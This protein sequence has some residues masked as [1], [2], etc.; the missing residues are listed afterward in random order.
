MWH[1]IMRWIGKITVTLLLLTGL[2][3]L[4]PRLVTAIHAGPRL[5][6][7]QEAPARTVAIVF[8]AGLQ[9]DGTPTAVLRDRVATAA[10]LY[11]SGKVKKIL[12]SGDNRFVEY[13]EPGAMA[14][15][16]I[17]LGVPEADIVLDYA[18]RR[19]YDTCYRAR[20]IFGIQEA[21][22]VTQRFHLPRALYLCSQLGIQALGVDADRQTY[23][24]RSLLIWH[25][26][27]TPATLVAL[28]ETHISHPLPVLGDPE[29]IF[30]LEAQ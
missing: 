30:P 2:A 9:R 21:L 18:G 6:S 28:W 15:Y 23:R 26:R 29:P 5:L 13:N 8:G 22:L 25:L 27:E 17:A 11:F 24:R 3:L 10:E 19:T 14:A 16:A 12:M 1:K 20:Q 4:V 7:L